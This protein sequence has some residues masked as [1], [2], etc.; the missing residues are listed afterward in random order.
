MKLSA[1]STENFLSK[2]PFWKFAVA[3]CLLLA[4]VQNLRHTAHHYASLSPKFAG[5]SS[6]LQADE[7]CLGCRVLNWSKS[8]I[9]S[10]SDQLPLPVVQLSV[11]LKDTPTPLLNLRLSIP[12]NAQA[13]PSSS[14]HS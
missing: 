14:F 3:V 1:R 13:P 11:S 2:F 4:C 8:F 6:S 12:Y 10:S 5:S 7:D 9:A